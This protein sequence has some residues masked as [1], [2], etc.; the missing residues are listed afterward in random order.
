M[1]VSF[2]RR[3]G[4]AIAALLVV[5]LGSYFLATRLSSNFLLPVSSVVLA[6]PVG[7]LPSMPQK[8][9]PGWINF[10]GCPPSGNG[11]DAALNLLKNRMDQGNYVPV[12]FDS[13]TALTWPKSVERRALNDWSSS[14]QAFISQYAGIPVSVE[15]Y[16]VNIRQGG[17]EPANCNRDDD[18]SLTWRMNLAKT[19]RAIRSQTIV[20]ESTAPSRLGHPWSI[21]LIYNLIVET[22]S[23]VRVSG[24]LYFDPEHPYE[25][26]RTRATLWEI[27]P[28]MKIEVYQDGTW[29]SLDRYGK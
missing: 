22:R 15:G 6:Q 3:G 24:W 7:D 28:V 17:P 11:G 14:G 23:R 5:G 1:L 18:V 4:W 2:L 10:D 25:L 19:P 13:I 27:L 12:S 8:P 26:G 9:E 29:N 21:E 16:I 20:V